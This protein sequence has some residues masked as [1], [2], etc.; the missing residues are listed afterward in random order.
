MKLETITN[1]KEK[2]EKKPLKTTKEANKD[3]TDPNLYQEL[4]YTM[5]DGEPVKLKEEFKH[6]ESSLDLDKV[7][8]IDKIRL[9]NFPDM[10][11]WIIRLKK[12]KGVRNPYLAQYFEPAKDEA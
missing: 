7:Y 10:S 2:N 1:K 9:R 11:V 5:N 8:Y 6:L 12:E 3:L 4:Q